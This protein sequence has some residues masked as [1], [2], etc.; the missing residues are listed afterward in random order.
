MEARFVK[1]SPQTAVGAEDDS[2]TVFLTFRSAFS[3]CLWMPAGHCQAP[4]SQTCEQEPR[5]TVTLGILCPGHLSG[6]GNFSTRL[7]GVWV[8][9]MA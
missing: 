3:L 2:A 6:M 4:E 7:A 8:Y 9:L 1:P 5:L